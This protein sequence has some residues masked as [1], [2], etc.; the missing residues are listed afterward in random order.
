MVPSRSGKVHDLL[1]MLKKGVRP[2]GKQEEKFLKPSGHP[3]SVAH[4]FA[5]ELAN[6]VHTK[7]LVACTISPLMIPCGAADGT[8]PWLIHPL[9][10]R[11]WGRTATPEVIYA[12]DFFSVNTNLGA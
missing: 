8:V 7:I 6:Q 12:S 11:L 5:G 3:F 1:P 9:S 2:L 10:P 4:L